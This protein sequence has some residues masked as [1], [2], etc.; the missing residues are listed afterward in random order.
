MRVA[1]SPCLYWCLAQSR[2]AHV[3]GLLCNSSDLP[4]ALILPPENVPMTVSTKLM[5]ADELLMLPDDGK[6]YELIEGVLNERTLAGAAHGRTA[7]EAGAL[8]YE[9]AH[10]RGPGAVFAPGTG[11]VLSTDPDTVR[12]PD[13]AFVAAERL[14]TGDLPAGYMRLAPDL[15]VE[16]VSPLDTASEL[17]SK[18]CTWLDAGCRVGV[19]RVPRHAVGHGLPVQRRRAGTGGR[20][21]SGRQPGIRWIQRRGARLV[22]LTCILICKKEPIRHGAKHRVSGY[23]S[24]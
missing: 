8:I 7:A 17:Q 10:L 5:T 13:A 20:G 23:Q 3:D 19:G 9:H 16:V 1:L 11:F 22:S 24:S 12:A 2:Q 14:P 15:V 21:Y 4:E 6:R 18:V